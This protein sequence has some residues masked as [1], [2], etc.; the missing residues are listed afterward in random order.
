MFRDTFT[1]PYEQYADREGEPFGVIRELTDQ[2]R[3]PEVGRMW[4]IEFEDGTQID[5]WPEE[6]ESDATWEVWIREQD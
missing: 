3:D 5:A 2:E 1:T 6:V 4:R